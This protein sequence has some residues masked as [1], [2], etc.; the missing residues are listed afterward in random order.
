MIADAD[1]QVWLDAQPSANQTV[2]IPYVKSVNDIELNYRM[3]LVQ[4]SGGSTSRISQQ[5][6]VTAAAAQPTAVARV[7]VGQQRGSECRIELVL[8]N[9]ANTKELGAYRF[10]CPR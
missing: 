8:R 1:L 5:G 2:M 7:A 10:E 3:E 6:K 9:Q 4:Q